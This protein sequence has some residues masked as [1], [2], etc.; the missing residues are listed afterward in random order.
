MTQTRR[1]NQQRRRKNEPTSVDIWKPVPDLGEGEPIALSAEPTTMIRSLGDPPLHNQSVVAAH[2]I[3]M[4]V[5]RAAGLA[6]AL[7]ASVDLLQ[8]PGDE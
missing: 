6:A 7:A 1:R 4:V 2:S 5:E 3:A 8:L